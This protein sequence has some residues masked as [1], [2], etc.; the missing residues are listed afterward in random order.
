MTDGTRQTYLF[1]QSS[2]R[3]SGTPYDAQYVLQGGAAACIQGESI[4]IG[5]RSVTMPFSWQQIVTG[6]NDSFLAYNVGSGAGVTITLEAG[7][8]TFKQLA[9]T[10]SLRMTALCGQQ[11]QVTWD[12]VDNKL[13]FAFATQPMFLV[14][15]SN[16]AGYMG[17]LQSD[18]PS[19]ASFASNY[20]LKPGSV[21]HLLLQ[22]NG[23]VPTKFNLDNAE[24]N[25]EGC[26]LSSVLAV[27]PINASP[28]GIITFDDS[29][30]SYTLDIRDTVIDR[31]QLTWL[32][33]DG[34]VASF[35]PDHQVA[36]LL[37]YTKAS[38][39]EQLLTSI[40][41]NIR[42]LLLNSSFE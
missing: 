22:I 19:G 2:N 36:L 5:L 28:Y 7:T 15:Y 33:P 34:T 26:R 39:T 20:P 21:D 14:F 3:H 31:L 40:D 35:V 32:S 12:A 9:I 27:V 8:Y 13:N 25:Q 30:S 10:L 18:S 23:V 37:T 29:F 24:N 17:F 1:L 11:V 4:T 41:E 42:L 16:L 38:L 6:S